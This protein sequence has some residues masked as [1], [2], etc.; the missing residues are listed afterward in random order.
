MARRRQILSIVVLFC[1]AACS[2]AAEVSSPRVGHAP[3]LIGAM[4]ERL[5]PGFLCEPGQSVPDDCQLATVGAGPS[6]IELPHGSI[7][8]APDSRFGASSCSRSAANRSDYSRRLAYNT[9][10][11]LQR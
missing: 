5:Q 6:L 4:P 11:R 3:G 10:R 8:I 9:G 7:H 1:S 2:S